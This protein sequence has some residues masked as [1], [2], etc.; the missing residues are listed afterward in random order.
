MSEFITQCPNCETSFNVTQPQLTAASGS[1]RCGACLQVFDARLT[2]LDPQEDETT[3]PQ[4]ELQLEESEEAASEVT[5]ETLEDSIPVREETVHDE[6]VYGRVVEEEPVD[7]EPVDEEPVDE[8]TVIEVENSKYEE[9]TERSYIGTKEISQENEPVDD[10]DESLEEQSIEASAATVLEVMS[11]SATRLDERSD[12]VSDVQAL[13]NPQTS[14]SSA[15]DEQMVS[16]AD[17]DNWDESSP[18]HGFSGD[19]P[20]DEIK[21]HEIVGEFDPSSAANLNNRWVRW[22]SLSGLA[23]LCLMGQFVWINRDALSQDVRLRSYFVTACN[24]IECNLA[25]FGDIHALSSTNLIIRSHPHL[26]L[27]HI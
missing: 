8:E 16:S 2:I 4:K 10:L 21:D 26:S 9:L 18:I 20:I 14:D 24:I 25:E 6:T 5:P 15:N 13:I 23:L 17:G 12:H 3:S 7:E 27:I 19:I 22:A 11:L 1:V